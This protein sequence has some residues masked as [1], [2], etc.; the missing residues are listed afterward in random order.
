MPNSAELKGKEA[1]QLAAAGLKQKLLKHI[2]TTK[3]D[4]FLHQFLQDRLF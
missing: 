1:T 2:E 3:L 4:F